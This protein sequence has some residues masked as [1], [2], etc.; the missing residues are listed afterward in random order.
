MGFQDDE[1]GDEGA[2]DG[3]EMAN[4]GGSSG[5]LVLTLF[6]VVV[7]LT[8]CATTVHAA[9]RA[10]DLNEDNWR[11]MLKDEWMVEL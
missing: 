9:N 7:A 3:D 4:G 1:S 6:A 11:L 10:L 5:S 2:A 8:T